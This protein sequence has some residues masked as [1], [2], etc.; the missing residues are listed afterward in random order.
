M[1]YTAFLPLFFLSLIACSPKE[2]T[3]HKT[4]QTQVETTNTQE[5][6]TAATLYTQQSAEYK[7]LCYQAYDLAALRL[8]TALNKGIKK[9]AVILDLDETVLDNS[10]YT[11]WQITSGNAY[12]SETWAQWTDLAAAEAVPGVVEFLNFA[13]SAGVSLFYISNRDT[14]ALTATMKN[15]NNLKM[16]QVEANHFFLKTTTS[17]KSERR[18]TVLDTG[19]DVVLYIG[20]NL[21]DYKHIWDKQS[22]EH[23]KQL[24]D[25][26]QTEMGKN[27]IALPNTLYGTWEGAL[28][29]FDHGL[30]DAQK[31]S[32][33]KANLVPAQL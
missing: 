19:Y 10:P 2:N 9:P 4:G 6:L 16:P 18:K 29:N 15:M 22:N 30:T 28:Y 32:A 20:D 12:S 8:Q 33:R 5:Y 25:S 23:R 13:D 21:G 14:S 11:A 26:L 27:Y 24:V 1:K 7:A 17:D 31:D 3:A